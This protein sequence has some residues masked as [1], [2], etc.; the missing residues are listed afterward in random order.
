M[1]H[2]QRTVSTLLER[3]VAAAGQPDALSFFQSIARDGLTLGEEHAP[4]FFTLADAGDAAA[5]EA[6]ESVAVQH[7]NDVLGVTNLLN[8]NGS[9]VHLVRA[10]GLHTA[11][12]SVFD[13][14]FDQE[15]ERAGVNTTSTVL[16]VVPVIGSLVHAAI[17]SNFGFGS[18][19]VE[20]LHADALARSDEFRAVERKVS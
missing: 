15:L 10:G 4:L 1:H 19:K 17:D 12:S 8:F 18:E 2:G 3:V 16:G 13:N 6:V 11:G 5:I 7:A 9:P 14:A 20:R